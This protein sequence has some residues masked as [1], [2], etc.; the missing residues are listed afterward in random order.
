MIANGE[1]LLLRCPSLFSA[2]TMYVLMAQ[3][4]DL[5]Q[6]KL[7]EH[8]ARLLLLACAEV[9]KTWP[10][11]SWIMK[12]FE[13]IFKNL[14][15]RSSAQVHQSVQGDSS[16]CKAPIEEGTTVCALQGTRRESQHDQ[17]SL[18]SYQDQNASSP[19]PNILDAGMLPDMPLHHQFL[20]VPEFFDQ[21][22]LSGLPQDFGV[23]HDVFPY[24][25]E[26]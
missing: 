21:D 2:L 13:T 1:I 16:H 3:S 15:E 26:T 9:A 14:E 17:A 22:L 10:A 11:C 6:R 8:K 4:P 25:M 5:M 23:A 24:L 20:D 18:N 7:A 19:Q 12:L